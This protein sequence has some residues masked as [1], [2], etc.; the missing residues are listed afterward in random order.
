[1][2]AGEEVL[3]VGAPVKRHTPATAHDE[4]IEP[5]LITVAP[6][7][8]R[9]A[10]PFGHGLIARGKSMWVSRVY[11]NRP[12]PLRMLP[13]RD[14]RF[15]RASPSLVTRTLQVRQETVR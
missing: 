15:V 2:R 3:N 13:R 14:A 12:A 7:H 8:R 9:A 6:I 1:V 10:L 11:P 4:A 5:R